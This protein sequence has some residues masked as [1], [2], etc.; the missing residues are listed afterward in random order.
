MWLQG[1]QEG[2]ENQRRPQSTRKKKEKQTHNKLIASHPFE[3]MKFEQQSN[4]CTWRQAL[5]RS[6][7]GQ[8]VSNSSVAGKRRTF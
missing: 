6:G 5:L 7:A 8:T 2:D 3:K 4:L 1:Q